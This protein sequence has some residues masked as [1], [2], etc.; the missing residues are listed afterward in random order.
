MK[1]NI[2]IWL[3]LLLFGLLIIGLVDKAHAGFPPLQEGQIVHWSKTGSKNCNSAAGCGDTPG[4]QIAEQAQDRIPQCEAAYPEMNCTIQQFSDPKE[5]RF[6]DRGV[7]YWVWR[8]GARVV[9]TPLEPCAHQTHEGGVPDGAQCGMCADGYIPATGAYDP[10]S[11]SSVTAPAQCMRNREPGEC[12]LEG[13]YEVQ[14][15]QGAYCVPE[16]QG[17]GADGYCIDQVEEDPDQ[18]EC[19]PDHPDFKGVAGYGG[20]AVLIC[21]DPQNNCKA[22]GD[23]YTWGV[24]EKNG[25]TVESCFPNAYNPPQCSGTDVLKRDQW[26]GFACLPLRKPGDN[27]QPGGPNDPNNGDS[28]GDGQGD[29]TGITGQ[30]QDIKKLLGR[31]NTNTDNINETLKGIG[32]QIKDGTKAI[33][34]A[35]GNI[36]GGGGGGGGNGSGDGG[37]GEQETPINWSGDPIDLKIGDGLEELNAIQGEYENLIANIRAE[38]AAS[39][40]SFTGQGT[41][42]DHT[43]T[44]WGVEVNAGLSKWANA[45]SIVG[46]VI[47][48]AAA[49]VALGIIMGAKD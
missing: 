17:I 42:Q 49:F 1:Q 10:E 43:F 7:T 6:V 18:P 41:L 47:V 5:V 23:G 11:G 44:V 48:F 32:K 16:C 27:D 28:D 33:T 39:F 34:D 40:G 14:T 21:G 36:P 30:L 22:L 29:I 24:V 15:E 26:G 19:G 8:G 3:S 25:T 12:Q 9:A 31:G 46:S 45:L 13:L 20:E 2:H 4:S 37:D 38:M 35:I